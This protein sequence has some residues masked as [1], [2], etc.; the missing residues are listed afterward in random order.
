MFDFFTQKKN[1]RK[2]GVKGKGTHQTCCVT[3]SN[4]LPR[5]G[6]SWE[7]LVGAKNVIFHRPFLDQ[8]SKIHTCFQNWPVERNYVIITQIGVQTKKFFKSIQNSHISPSFFHIT[9][10]TFIHSR[11]SLENHTRFQTKM[12]IICTRFQTKKAQTPYPKGGGGGGHIPIQLTF[13]HFP[14]LLP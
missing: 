11:S 13:S 2:K 10:N 8:T 3:E 5:G 4:L 14:G 7:F 6:Y 1:I 12:G 9:I